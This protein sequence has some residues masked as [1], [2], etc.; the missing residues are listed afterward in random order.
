MADPALRWPAEL[1]RLAAGDEDEA[2]ELLAMVWGPRFDREHALHWLMASR[3]ADAQAIEAM[4]RFASTFD[5]L[6][7]PA[8]RVVRQ[9]AAALAHNAACRASC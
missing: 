7:P 5:A 8:Q 9:T 6:P 3:A 4:H 1:A 2:L